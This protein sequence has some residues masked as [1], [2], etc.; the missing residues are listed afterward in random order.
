MKIN[1]IQDRIIEEFSGLND[2]L[3]KYEHLV[4]L[5]KEL[6]VSY[7]GL[8]NED[9]LISGCQ[10]NVWLKGKIK[11]NKFFFFADSEALITKGIIS[12]LLR[13]LNNQTPSDIVDADLYFIDKIGLKSN[14]SPSRSNGLA[15]IVKKIKEYGAD[16]Q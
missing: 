6:K 8:R 10:S 3:D 4:K 14:L 9:N 12:L 13:V 5:G 1:K 16:N 15:L 2:G 7:E 11:D